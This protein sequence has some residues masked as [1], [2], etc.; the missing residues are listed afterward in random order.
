MPSSTRRRSEIVLALQECIEQHMLKLHYQPFYAGGGGELLGFEA[1]LRLHDPKLGAISPVEFIPIAEEIGLIGKLGAWAL[2]EA[3]RTASLWPQH[4]TIAVNV[5]PEQFQGGSLLTDVHN[6]LEL[7]SFPAYRLEVEITES[8]MMNDAE[9]VSSQISALKELGC[10]IVLDDFGTGYSSL[11]YLWKY[12]FS[13][14]KIDRSFMAAMTHEP[15]VRGMM[16]SIL[17]LSKNLGLKVTAEGIE[18]PEQA[19]LMQD[20]KCD[21]MQGYLFG[22]PMPT[23]DVA[24]TIMMRF[25]QGLQSDVLP[26]DTIMD[27]STIRKLGTA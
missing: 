27:I 8:T 3:C 23:E 15:R 11:S 25:A 17:Q 18:T 2:I 22:K 5:S 21:Y 10:G 19:R 1:L 14:L 12:P 4:L 7:S 6:A 16:S 9:L 26:M 13:K 24:A 20:M